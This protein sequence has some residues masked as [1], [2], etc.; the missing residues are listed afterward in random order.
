MGKVVGQ[1]GAGDL[2]L[3]V[4][5]VA[6]GQQ[7]Q[8]MG[9]GQVGEHLLDVGQR[10]N[11]HLQQLFAIVQNLANLLPRHRALCQIEGR[12]NHGQ[13]EAFA[14]VAKVGEVAHFSL[15]QFPLGPRR[16]AIRGQ[17]TLKAIF[18][19]FKVNL[20]VPQ[21]IVGVKGN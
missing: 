21:G 4:E 12:L 1:A 20:I 15:V 11:R 7:H 18:G 17:Q 14:A 13:G 9:A 16:I 10:F 5:Q 2:G 6:L 8:G 3:L 19:R